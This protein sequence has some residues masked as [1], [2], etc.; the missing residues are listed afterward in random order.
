MSALPRSIVGSLHA[1]VTKV[2]ADVDRVIG[3]VQSLTAITGKGF[4]TAFD[5]TTELRAEIRTEFRELNVKVDQ[6]LAALMR[7]VEGRGQA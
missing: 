1:D 6:V 5:Q 4:E 3:L 2:S 7:I